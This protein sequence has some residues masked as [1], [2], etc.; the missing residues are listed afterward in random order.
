LGDAGRWA[1][2]LKLGKEKGFTESGK[3]LRVEEG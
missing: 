3:R 1:R 2:R